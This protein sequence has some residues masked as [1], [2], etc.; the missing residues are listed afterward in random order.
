MKKLFVS[1]IVLLFSC[2]AVFAARKGHVVHSSGAHHAVGLGFQYIRTLLNFS[3]QYD[4]SR[5]VS[6]QGVLGA[7]DEDTLIAGKFLYKFDYRSLYS[8]YG[9]GMLGLWHTHYHHHYYRYYDWHED[10]VMETVP[11]LGVGFG[12]EYNW[13]GLNRNLPQI[14][15]NI[16]LGMFAVN[17][18][19]DDAHSP[20]GFGINV[21]AHY[22]F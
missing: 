13:Q 16:E 12:V 9:Y 14:W 15:W 19:D 17:Y 22:K 8:L 20:S 2:S 11:G 6:L 3:I 18:H 1:I 5:A 21:G 10:G 7:R 4:C